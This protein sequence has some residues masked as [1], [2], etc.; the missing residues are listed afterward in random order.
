M[1]P[2]G[3]QNYQLTAAPIPEY[4]ESEKPIRH[5]GSSFRSSSIFPLELQRIHFGGEG[6]RFWKD[7]FTSFNF[8][9]FAVFHS[10]DVP[11]SLLFSLATVTIANATVSSAFQPFLLPLLHFAVTFPPQNRGV[12]ASSLLSFPSGSYLAFNYFIMDF[13]S[14]QFCLPSPLI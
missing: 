9:L 11:W 10:F 4:P 7:E 12:S 2:S 1:S 5:L 3:L 13:S 6:R 8:P 14:L